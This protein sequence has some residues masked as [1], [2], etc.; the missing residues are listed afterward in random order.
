MALTIATMANMERYAH[1]PVFAYSQ[2]T[3]ERYSANP[4]DYWQEGEDLVLTDSEGQPMVLAMD[5]IAL[6]EEIK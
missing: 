3:G 1:R 2:I 5:S 6:L 4:A